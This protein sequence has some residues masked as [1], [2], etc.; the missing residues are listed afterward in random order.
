MK[1]L[2]ATAIILF[3]STVIFGQHS[4]ISKKVLDQRQ[5]GELFVKT[6]LFKANRVSIRSTVLDEY[7]KDYTRL[8]LDQKGLKSLLTKGHQAVEVNIPYGDESITLELVKSDLYAA[9]FNVKTSESPNDPVEYDP[10]LFYQGI[11]VGSKA[12]IVALSVFNDDIIGVFETAE[13]GNM[14]LGKYGAK[15]QSDY[16]LYEEDKLKITNDFSCDTKDPEWD[17][18]QIE[19]IRK[20]LSQKSA[21]IRAEKCVNIYFELDYDLYKEKGSAAAATNFLSGIFN[22]V[23]T[24]YANENIEMKISEVYVWTSPDS[25]GTGTTTS[26]LTSFRNNNSSFNGDVAH[27]ISRGNPSN[28]GI[29]WVDA[30]CTSYAY[31]YSWV[32]STY[33]NF[34]TY[35]WTVNVVTHETGHVLGSPHTHSC[36]WPGGAIDNCYTP[37]PSSGCSKGPAP[38]GGGTIMS[39]CHLTSYGINFNQ[40]FGPEPGDLIRSR[41]NNSAC[42]TSCSGGGAGATCNDGIQNGNETGVDCGGGCNPCATCNDGAKNGNE[43]GVDCGG[44]CAPCAT[45]NDG[46]QNGNETGID[47]G[48]D[49]APCVTCND[50]IQNGNETG[51]DC[52]GT[53]GPCVVDNYCVSSSDNTQYEHIKNVTFA[54]INNNSG[55]EGYGNFT[56][57]TAQVEKGKTYTLSVTPHFAGSA[58]AEH[59]SVWM[60]WNGDG[61]LTDAGEHVVETTGNKKISISIKV[62]VNASNGKTRMRI[63]MQWNK[64]ITN[65]CSNLSYGEVEDYSVSISG[66]TSSPTCNDGI[67]NGNETGVDCGGSCAPCTTCND[68]IKNGNE[69]GVDCGGDCSPCTTCNDGIQNGDESGVDCGGSCGPCDQSS[70]CASK[71]TTT[72]YEYIKNVSFADL[73]NSSKADAGY[74]D[75]TS[76]TANVGKGKTY[77]L[78]ITPG[79]NGSAYIE[80]FNAYIDWNGD[81]DFSDTGEKVLAKNGNSTVKANVTVPNNS[82]QGVTRMRIQ[83]QWNKAAPGPCSI[84]TYGEVED[85]SINIGG[86]NTPTC[87]DGVM[88]GNETGVD[89]GGGCNPCST[90][91]DG[92]ENGNE[93]GI[94]CGGDCIPCSTC[95][96]GIKNGNETGVDCGGDCGPCVTNASYCAS[97]SSKT[98]YEWIKLVKLGSINNATGSDGGYGDYTSLSTNLNKSSSYGITLEPHYAGSAYNEGWNV[99]IDFNQDGDFTDQ[100]ELVFEILAKNKISGTIQVPPNAKTGTTRMRVQMQWNKKTSSSCDNF[101]W[102]EVEDYSVNIGSSPSLANNLITLDP[103]EVTIFPN[104]VQNILVVKPKNISN[105]TIFVNV[106]NVLGKQILQREIRGKA[107][108]DVSALQAGYYLMEF[109]TG[110]EKLTKQFIKK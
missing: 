89:C 75:Y 57:Q 12:S 90:C 51:V 81:G 8:T 26:A 98:T 35:S 109:D 84:L 10:G 107:R 58:Y 61:D 22:S 60:D 62:P 85:Y 94:D 86:G 59:F 33:N 82:L 2:K 95:N 25:Y 27:L 50:G 66:T 103:F 91:D 80:F 54:G 4:P 67:Q 101:G 97:S 71:S 29:A 99:Y 93:T 69:T 44:D 100:D 48:G 45:C 42:L 56:A 36:S 92:I 64:A 20:I 11:V 88:N 1:C 37:E 49:C 31:A 47:C 74:G 23:Q 6:N 83:M 21:S 106:Y 5:K 32:N 53:C 41:I 28:G 18:L 68:G 38:S 30:L 76:K 108:F 52:G 65:P 15:G 40:G 87:G 24:L 70:Y 9:G 78:R 19:E 7:I 102:G 43:T 34:P 13:H 55:K 110:F 104:P 39:Y 79:Y 46:I 3:Y 14:V 72:Q 63:S 96:D 73:N 77:S 16:V 17:A 105:G